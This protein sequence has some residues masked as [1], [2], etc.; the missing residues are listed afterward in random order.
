LHIGKLY[1]SSTSGTPQAKNHK[2]KLL[3]L[4]RTELRVNHYSK[5]L[6]KKI[7]ADTIYKSEI[8]YYLRQYYNTYLLEMGE[9]IRTVQELL[10]HKSVKTTLIYTHVLN[11]GLG[12]ISPL[13]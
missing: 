13:D 1:I 11:R 2:P 10:G 8:P 5:K 9:D 4:V 12:V 7:K 3:D 6:K